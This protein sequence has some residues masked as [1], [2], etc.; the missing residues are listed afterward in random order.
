MK[1]LPPA[2]LLPPT[3]QQAG[4]CLQGT[5]AKVLETRKT[6]P[7][8]RV[9]DKW[10][11]LIGG[12]ANHRMGLFDMVMIKDNHVTAAGGVAPAIQRA[13]VGTRPPARL[14][15]R[16]HSMLV[17]AALHT[18][19]ALQ[20]LPCTACLPHT[21]LLHNVELLAGQWRASH[22][23][24]PLGSICRPSTDCPPDLLQDS[25]EKHRVSDIR[26]ADLRE[27]LTSTPACCTCWPSPGPHFW[28]HQKSSGTAGPPAPGPVLPSP[29]QKT[30]QFVESKNYSLVDRNTSSCTLQ[31]FL[32][33]KQ[34][35]SVPIEV[36]T[37]TLEEVQEVLSLMDHQQHEGVARLMLD[38]MTRLD[39]SKPGV[40]NHGADRV[41]GGRGGWVGGWCD[42]HVAALQRLAVAVVL[43]CT[44]GPA[45]ALP[46]QVHQALDRR[47][48]IHMQHRSYCVQGMGSC[49]GSL[50]CWAFQARCAACKRLRSSTG[51][52]ALGPCRCT[53]QGV[54]QCT[55]LARASSY[56]E[57]A[58]CPAMCRILRCTVHADCAAPSAQTSPFWALEG[59]GA[60]HPMMAGPLWEL[61][62]GPGWRLKLRLRTLLGRRLIAEPGLNQ[63]CKA[64][65]TLSFVGEL[66]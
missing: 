65:C 26:A 9:P 19:P 22:S 57:A 53:E 60:L 62:C 41:G 52:G 36:E 1:E 33:R 7:C 50:A 44:P 45:C 5:G 54:V 21:G 35:T 47:E 8:L 3:L 56:T 4:T 16:G 40:R 39:S 12:G 29:A 11:V 18:C 24:I 14:P 23:C 58:A 32:A 20:S 49:W 13:Q 51:E 61:A 42:V 34:L 30:W 66:I 46:G 10:A 17:L 55:L 48:E 63:S 37:R 25:C 27:L 6:V 15:P 59:A 31:E 28:P 64:R 2:V 38:N 43:G